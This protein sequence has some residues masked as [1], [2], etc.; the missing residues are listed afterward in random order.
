[1]S[2]L[3]DRGRGLHC[4]ENMNKRLLLDIAHQENALIKVR[5]DQLPSV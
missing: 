1:M 4:L 3:V 2:W 5:I